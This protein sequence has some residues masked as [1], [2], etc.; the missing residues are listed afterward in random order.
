MYSILRMT[1][2]GAHIVTPD[3]AIRIT[4]SMWVKGGSCSTAAF[5]AGDVAARWKRALRKRWISEDDVPGEYVNQDNEPVAQRDW[6][7]TQSEV[8]LTSKS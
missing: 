5:H 8:R 4:V 6:L 2:I 7:Q 1:P 3:A